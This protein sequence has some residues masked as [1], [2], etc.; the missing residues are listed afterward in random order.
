MLYVICY[1]FILYAVYCV[2]VA[3]QVIRISLRWSYLVHV[4]INTLTLTENV[5]VASTMFLQRQPL[6]DTRLYMTHVLPQVPEA[7]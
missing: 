3:C 5:F 4:T 2:D 6:Y 7:L 1:F